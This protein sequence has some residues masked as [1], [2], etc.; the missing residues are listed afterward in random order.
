MRRREQEP[1]KGFSYLLGREKRQGEPSLDKLCTVLQI[2]E[3][4]Y[5]DGHVQM[6][7]CL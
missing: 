6:A 2:A 4:R 3:Q 7:V 1:G 5:D